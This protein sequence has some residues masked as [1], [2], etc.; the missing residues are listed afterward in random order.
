MNKVLHN[1]LLQL[2]STPADLLPKINAEKSPG[3]GGTGRG[4][5]KAWFMSNQAGDYPLREGSGGY[6]VSLH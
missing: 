1:I 3:L 4:L 5:E 6:K 2:R